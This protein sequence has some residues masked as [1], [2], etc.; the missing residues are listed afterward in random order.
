[1]AFHTDGS[2]VSTGSPAAGGETISMLGTGFG[3]Y[4]TPVLDGFFPSNPPPA[5]ADS[6][7]LSVGGTTTAQTST[8]A[9]GFTGVVSTK[10]QVPSGLT[11][12]SSVPV[13]VTINGVESNTVMLPIQ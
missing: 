8:A 6:V 10:F 3:P 11:S 2:M 9:P 13:L 1:M 4:Q 7:V 12:G 5:V